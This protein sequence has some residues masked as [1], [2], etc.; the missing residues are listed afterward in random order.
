MKLEII[1]QN[2]A[3]CKLCELSLTRNL[4]VPG[5]GSPNSKIFLVGE[6][7]G[8]N[9]DKTGK[10]FCGSAGNILT[11]VL[12]HIG[13]DRQDVFITSIVKCRPPKN[14]LPK[15]TEAYLCINTHL[16]PQ[17]KSIKPKVIVLMG[18][19]AIRHVFD[20]VDIKEAHGTFK[21]KEGRTYFLTYHPAAI[22]YRRQLMDVIKSD[23][24]KLKKL[25]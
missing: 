5:E 12:N 11:E 21:V 1:H 10:P 23:F 18:L 20:K 13:I 17:I 16:I 8:K 6:A 2:I 25:I 19:S 7:P 3:N 22:L 14:R 24:E 15:K 9:E 4:T